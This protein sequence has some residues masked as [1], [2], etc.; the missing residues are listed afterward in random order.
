[1]TRILIAEDDAGLREVIVAVL[2]DEGFVAHAVPDGAAAL[3]VLSSFAPDLLITDIEMPGMSGWELLPR[4]HEHLPNLPVLFISA[5][6]LSRAS[7]QMDLAPL[8]RL[9]PKPFGVDELLDCIAELLQPA[10]QE[11][12]RSGTT[13]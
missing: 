10:P 8:V 2:E 1:M 13:G 7:R 5:G 11:P 4:V 12:G 3:A 9:L 6:F